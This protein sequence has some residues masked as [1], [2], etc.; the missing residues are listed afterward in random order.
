MKLFVSLLIIKIAV[1]EMEFNGFK[2]RDL[3]F[4]LLPR[5]KKIST[6]VLFFRLNK[7]RIKFLSFYSVL[8]V[9][10]LWIAWVKVIR[11]VEIKLNR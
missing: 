9:H 4:I 10:H 3:L 11:V 2:Y 1:M 6:F 5:I 7:M 8:L